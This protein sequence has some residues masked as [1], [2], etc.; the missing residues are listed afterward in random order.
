MEVKV[1]FKVDHD[2]YPLTWDNVMAHEAGELFQAQDGTYFLL[3]RNYHEKCKSDEQLK[4]LVGFGAYPAT[5]G[6]N[7]GYVNF[8]NIRGSCELV[9]TRT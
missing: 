5:I 8:R 6:K 9:V 2:P 3:V 7:S 4:M 1:V